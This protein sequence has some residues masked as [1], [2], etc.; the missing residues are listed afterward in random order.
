MNFK[1]TLALGALAAVTFATACRNTSGLSNQPRAT[2]SQLAC[3]DVNRDHR[4][5]DADA[6]DP[7]KLPDFNA[8]RSR[9]DDDAAFLLGTDI[10]LDP[11]FD[12]AQCEG[13]AKK[14]PEYLVAHGYFDPSDVSC[15]DDA[16]PVLLVGVGGGA[17]NVRD[18]DDAAGVRKVVDK[19]LGEYE[20]HDVDAIAVIA[21]P[22]IGGAQNTNAAMEDWITNATRV[23][24]ERYPCLSAVLIGH[25]L[26]AVVVDVAGARLEDAYGERMIA[27][28]D[29]DR[30]FR[31][32]P[33]DFYSGDEISRPDA[34]YVFNVY[35]TNDPMHADPYN[36]P[37]AENWD[38][39]GVDGTDGEPVVH[40]TID[41]SPAVHDRIVD[42]VLERSAHVA[43]RD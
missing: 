10:V 4:I 19:L 40:T 1:I 20:D 18:K 29:I 33:L 26:G 38:A 31:A 2:F 5:S 25:S 16:R 39:S 43:R 36:M 6:A 15:D 7:S 3:L 42:E 23:Y 37:N 13:K 22:A 27:V 12:Y 8:D 34:A 35:E 24:L 28:V 14:T 11:A 17:V 32:G 9:D 30:V 41:N 21:G